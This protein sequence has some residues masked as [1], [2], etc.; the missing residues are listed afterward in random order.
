[1][2][3]RENGGLRQWMILRLREHPTLIKFKGLQQASNKGSNPNNLESTKIHG[4][5]SALASGSEPVVRRF[6]SALLM[7]KRIGN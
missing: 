1:M 5:Q 6:P 7:P 3:V 2:R 4:F